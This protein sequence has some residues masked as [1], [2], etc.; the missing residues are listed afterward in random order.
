ML[1]PGVFLYNRDKLGKSNIVSDTLLRLTS[2]EYRLSNSEDFV[3]DILVTKYGDTLYIRYF[4]TT[5][6][7]INPEFRK[8]LT[9]RIAEELR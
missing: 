4:P 3:L 9:T 8:R 5:L 7:E 1:A 2:R 6:V